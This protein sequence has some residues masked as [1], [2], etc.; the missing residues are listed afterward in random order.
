MG[1]QWEHA[2]HTHPPQAYHLCPPA[3]PLILRLGLT[4]LHI[5]DP[6]GEV[7]VE[8]LHDEHQILSRGDMYSQGCGEFH[9]RRQRS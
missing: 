9:S 1:T 3:H 8:E 4:Y 5:Q 2:H 7:A 6:E